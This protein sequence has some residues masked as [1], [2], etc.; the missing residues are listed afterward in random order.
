M[1][2]LL[3]SEWIWVLVPSA[4]R[5]VSTMT[6]D[7]PRTLTLRLLPVLSLSASSPPGP[8]LLLRDF[9]DGLSPSMFLLLLPLIIE[10]RS[11]V[12]FSLF[13]ALADGIAP[14][15]L[16]DLGFAAGRVMSSREAMVA[17]LYMEVKKYYSLLWMLSLC[18]H[19]W[20]CI[21]V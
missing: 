4:V 17:V 6:Y 9:F 13:I 20:G 10:P 16:R 7:L 18:I 8:I 3:A 12:M 14:R 19:C 21:Y 1:A 5:N 11:V 15:D 2:I